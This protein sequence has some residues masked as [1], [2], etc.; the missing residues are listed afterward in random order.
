MQR[1]PERVRQDVLNGIIS[2][3]KARNDYGVVLTEEGVD[4]DATT[5]LLSEG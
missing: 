5:E 1:D 2:P 4:W 3:T